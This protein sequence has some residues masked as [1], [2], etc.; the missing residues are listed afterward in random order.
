V[1]I[2]NAAANIALQLPLIHSALVSIFMPIISDVYNK[3]RFS[4]MKELYDMVK[5]WSSY[6]TFFLALPIIFYPKLVMSIYGGEFVEGWG[7]LLVLPAAYIIGSIAGPTGAL[8]QMTG[9]QNIEFLNGFFMVTTNVLLNYFLIPI[10]GYL[11]A[12]IATLLATSFMNMVQLGQIYRFFGFHPFDLRHIG[13][14]GLAA[15]IFVTGIA[16]NIF[17]NLVFNLPLFWLAIGLLIGY[18]Y[19]TRTKEDIVIW[20]AVRNRLLG[21]WLQ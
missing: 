17:G 21:R 20:T 10:Y 12:A 16:G 13:F 8:L 9:R 2:Y 1:G 19:K 7:I 14:V 4:E 5:R 6:G 15:A 3:Q 11:G 18:G